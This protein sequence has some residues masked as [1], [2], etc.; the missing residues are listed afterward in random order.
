[1]IGQNIISMFGELTPLA[2]SVFVSLL[3]LL[4][5]WYL[6]RRILAVDAGTEKMREIQELIHRGA[7]AFLWREYK[8]IACFVFIVAVVI[9]FS[10]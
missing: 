6:V 10:T 2:I 5:V 4:F 8:V 1:M 7:M 9:F 3:G